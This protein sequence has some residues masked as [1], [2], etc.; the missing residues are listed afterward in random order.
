MS[1]ETKDELHQVLV[2][3]PGDIVITRHSALLAMRQA[4]DI[5]MKCLE[6]L[7]NSRTEEARPLICARLQ[8]L[9]QLQ[10][11]VANIRDLPD[12]DLVAVCLDAIVRS[13]IRHRIDNLDTTIVQSLS[14]NDPALARRCA[15]LHE[16]RDYQ[17]PRNVV[18]VSYYHLPL[19]NQTKK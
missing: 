6:D 2:E 13:T 1:V 11:A 18:K 3:A 17:N 14:E 10:A 12:S 7:M 8:H 19:F 15:C 16:W 5:K 4:D 9:D